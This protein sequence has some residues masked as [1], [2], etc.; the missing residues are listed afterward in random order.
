ML[1]Q[2]R[3]SYQI[4][5]A[6]ESDKSMGTRRGSQRTNLKTAQQSITPSG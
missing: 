6:N 5:S 1:S 3:M 2:R 4:A